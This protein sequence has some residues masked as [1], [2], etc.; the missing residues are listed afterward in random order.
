MQ[1]Q[2]QQQIQYSMNAL[3]QEISGDKQLIERFREIVTSFSRYSKFSDEQNTQL[4]NMKNKLQCMQLEL[5]D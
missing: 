5:Q 1:A 2:L 4:L 3:L